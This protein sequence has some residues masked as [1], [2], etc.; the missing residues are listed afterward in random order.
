MPGVTHLPRGVD[1]LARRPG[2]ATFG[3]GGDDPAV[4]DDDG[5]AL[6]RLRPV[7]ERDRAA[8][9]GDGLGGERARRRSEQQR[10]S[11]RRGSL[12]VS[13]AGLAELEVADRAQPRVGRVVQQR[14]VDPDLSGRV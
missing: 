4:A 13:F 12:H 5:A 10:R 8:G 3:A 14:A 11:A 9:D 1:H 2:R 7:A 6:D